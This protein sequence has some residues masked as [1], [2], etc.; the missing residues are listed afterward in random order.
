MGENLTSFVATGTW[1]I[2]ERNRIDALYFGVD[3]D[4][5]RTSSRDITVDDQVGV[6]ALVLGTIS[7]K[8]INITTINTEPRKD[9]AVMYIGIQVK[10]QATLERLLHDLR[11]LKPIRYV[12][13]G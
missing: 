10:D 3:R 4:G 6:A 8:D 1:R 9:Y 13:I 12:S 11:A 2:S 7:H 5:S